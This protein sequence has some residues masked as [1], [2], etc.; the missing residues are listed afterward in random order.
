LWCGYEA[1]RAQEE[2]KMIF[3]ARASNLKQLGAALASTI[4]AG[5]LG[6]PIGAC[7]KPLKQDWPEAL[8]CLVAITV[9]AASATSSSNCC[10]MF[11]NRLGAFLC[12]FMIPFWH[13]LG[14]TAMISEAFGKV[15]LAFL[16][17]IVVVVTSMCFFFL[18]ETDRVSDQITRLEALQLCRGFEGSITQAA[19]SEAA[20]KARIFQEIGEKTDAVDHAIS[21][22]LA[23][24][25]SSPTLTQVARAGIDIQSAGHA[26][27]ALPFAALMTGFFALARVCFQMVY[28]HKVFFAWIQ[29]LSAGARLA[30]VFVLWMSSKDER[31]FVLKMMAKLVALDL[32]ILGPCMVLWE[33]KPSGGSPHVFWFAAPLVVHT[34]MLALACLGMRQ[35]VSLRCGRCLLQIFLAR[36]VSSFAGIF[37]IRRS[38]KES[39]TEGDTE[40]STE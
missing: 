13:T 35:L 27:I 39:E 4:L 31:C 24:G 38:H 9:A 16:A 19:C 37:T 36:G 21:V 2:G 17:Q 33:V 40:T 22:L 14:I 30:L 12:G 18:L 29:I 10:R 28:L 6:I 32:L 1:Y 20:D 15:S 34:I 25:M 3:I 7:T 26:E 5:L 11:C 23:A 8:L